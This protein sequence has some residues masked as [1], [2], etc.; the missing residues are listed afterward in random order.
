M[1]AV[2]RIHERLAGDYSHGSESQLR[3]VLEIVERAIMTGVPFVGLE[4]ETHLHSLAV[5]AL[6]GYEQQW[7]CTDA[8]T[9]HS[10]A[11]RDGLWR[12]YGKHAQPEIRAFLKGLAEG[13]PIF[14]QRSAPDG[15]KYAA[16]SVE[17]LRTF[18]SGLSALREQVVYRVKRKKVP[19]EE[20][21]LAAEFATEF[22]GWIDQIRQAGLDVFYFAD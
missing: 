19:S 22:P 14:G 15:P 20:D 5:Y 11:L 16:I 8:S 1:K 4:E 6:A 2:N 3:A 13:V 7:L 18:E 9:Y 21:R 10:S 17:K 12:Q